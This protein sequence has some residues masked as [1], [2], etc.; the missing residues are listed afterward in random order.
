MV[1]YPVLNLAHRCS[2]KCLLNEHPLTSCVTSGTQNILICEVG[3]TT[4]PLSGC[5]RYGTI[6]GER[7]S[8]PSAVGV[9]EI[10]WCRCCF[11]T[12]QH[13]PPTHTPARRTLH[14]V[15]CRTLPVPFPGTGLSPSNWT[16]CHLT[17]VPRAAASTKRTQD[18]TREPVH[19]YSQIHTGT[20]PIH[21]TQPCT[22]PHLHPC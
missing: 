3:I 2:I 16:S 19:M 5:V 13:H 6:K 20:V 7:S 12:V 11:S 4:W 17:E 21:T 1:C 10:F 18:A 22:L 8:L 15:P 9:P 14:C